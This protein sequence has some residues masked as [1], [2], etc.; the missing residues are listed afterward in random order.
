MVVTDTEGD[1][2]E[3]NDVTL[4]VRPES[5]RLSSEST[6]GENSFTSV[7]TSIAFIGDSTKY[8]VQLDDGQSVAVRLQQGNGSFS[9]GDRVTIS[10]HPAMGRLIQAPRH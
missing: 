6:S 7:V 5:I 1:W 4:I 8:T 2:Y 10:W 3:G 9:Q